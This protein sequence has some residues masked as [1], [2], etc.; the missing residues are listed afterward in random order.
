MELL[1]GTGV[2]FPAGTDM[3]GI[4]PEAWGAFGALWHGKGIL[5]GPQMVTQSSRLSRK[6]F[7]SKGC[8]WVKLTMLPSDHS[9]FICSFK[10]L[11]PI[12]SSSTSG[13]QQERAEEG[14]GEVSLGH[15]Q[16]RRRQSPSLLGRTR[17][18]CRGPALYPR[19]AADSQ[20]LTLLDLLGDELQLVHAVDAEQVAPAPQT[21]LLGLLPAA[22]LGLQAV[23][24]AL[25]GLPAGLAL[26]LHIGPHICRDPQGCCY[27]GIQLLSMG[28]GPTGH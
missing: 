7:G 19:P 3:T 1:K 22:L 24:V 26:H 14:H 10:S 8:Q 15:Q 12:H 2:R 13:V 28:T 6:L 20:H 9:K 23:A 18:A 17:W 25:E 16:D 5:T 27:S 11:R 4:A 21:R